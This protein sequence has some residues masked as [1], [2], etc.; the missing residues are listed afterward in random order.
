MAI[1]R[2]KFPT[3]FNMKS[4]VPNAYAETGGTVSEVQA[5]RVHIF[6][7]PGE[8]TFSFDA[9]GSFEVLAWGAGGAAAIPSGWGYGSNGGGGG[10]IGGVVN[11]AG[12][13][14]SIIVGS[15]GAQGVTS[16]VGYYGY[17]GAA[18]NSSYGSMGG[19]LSGLFLPG[20]FTPS[21]AV[22]IAGG[23]GGGGSSRAGTGNYGGAGG[24]IVGQDGN[25][26]Y[27]G[28]TEYRGRGGTQSGTSLPTTGNTVSPS[29]F[30]GGVPVNHGGS[31]GGGWWGGSGG[32]YSES[33]TMGGGGGGSGYAN[34]TYVVNPSNLT[35]NNQ[36]SANTA[37][38]FWN[39][40]GTG[41]QFNGG[42]GAHGAVIIKYYM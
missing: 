39:G 26:P 41:G 31:G 10:F 35:G 34:T 1:S 17:G 19:G 15:G 4:S 11:S 28:K 6:D 13:S 33:N 30:G 40:Y 24:G 14:F 27:D 16:P 18:I 22:V 42:S 20:G 38:M 21:N 5:Y 3:F 9:E 25:S 2:M 37:N 29:Q 36:T 8:Y 12:L 32:A 7:V 23:G